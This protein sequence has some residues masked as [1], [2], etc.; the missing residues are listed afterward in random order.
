MKQSFHSKKSLTAGHTEVT[1]SWKGKCFQVLSFSTYTWLPEYCSMGLSAVR[2]CFILVCPSW[3]FGITI[4]LIAFITY[5]SG[6]AT[7]ISIE[8][9]GNI[10][11]HDW[12]E[13]V[14]SAPTELIQNQLLLCLLRWSWLFVCLLRWWWDCWNEM[15]R[16]PIESRIKVPCLEMQIGYRTT[17]TTSTITTTTFSSVNNNNNNNNNNNTLFCTAHIIQTLS[18]LP[19]I[20]RGKSWN[21]ANI[22]VMLPSKPCNETWQCAGAGSWLIWARLCRTP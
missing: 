12:I 5:L 6:E 16:L 4:I 17:A 15:V 7:F 21:G 3:C 22:I 11:F 9:T 14:Q 18:A 20:N 8:S 13:W 19:V 2:W 1:K 10:I